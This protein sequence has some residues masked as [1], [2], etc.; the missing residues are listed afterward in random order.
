MKGIVTGAFAVIG[1]NDENKEMNKRI[2]AHQSLPYVEQVL[3]KE[4]KNI[5]LFPGHKDCYDLTKQVTL[6]KY[7]E[8]KWLWLTVNINRPIPSLVKLVIHESDS[9]DYRPS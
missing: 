5:E 1:N 4:N 9:R 7:F 2:M 6:W 3:Q 8:K